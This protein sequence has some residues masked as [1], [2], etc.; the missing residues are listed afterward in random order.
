MNLIFAISLELD[1]MS[2][3]GSLQY[4]CFSLRIMRI[5]RAAQ[6]CYYEPMKHINVKSDCVSR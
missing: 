3:N 4:A 5:L 6:C 1:Y 2:F